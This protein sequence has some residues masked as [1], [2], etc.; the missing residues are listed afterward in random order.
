MFFFDQL[1]A[2]TLS[3]VHALD[4]PSHWFFSAVQNHNYADYAYLVSQRASIDNVQEAIDVWQ[5][6]QIQCN[7]V[8]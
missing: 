2:L 5:G 7:T 6:N 8:A 3:G 1:T 4:E